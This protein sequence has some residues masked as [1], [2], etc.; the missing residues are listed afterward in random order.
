M[1]PFDK[2]LLV[3]GT[4]QTGNA[5]FQIFLVVFS[6][7]ARAVSVIFN[8][9]A[10][11]KK[12]LLSEKGV[13]FLGLVFFLFHWHKLDCTENTIKNSGKI[14]FCVQATAVSVNWRFRLSLKNCFLLEKCCFPNLVPFFIHWHRPNSTENAIKFFKNIAF[15]VQARAVSV[16]WRFRL[17]LKKWLLSRKGY[18]SWPGIF[19]FTDTDSILH[20]T[21]SKFSKR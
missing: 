6:I 16:N 7:S 5:T 10:P 11:R 8:S 19:L 15:C 12:W 2:A 1:L 3:L 17:T 13:F 18:F 20:K 14:A 4:A 21:L 9:W